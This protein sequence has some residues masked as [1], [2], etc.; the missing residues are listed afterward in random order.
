MYSRYE[1]EGFDGISNLSH[2]LSQSVPNEEATKPAVPTM[3]KEEITARITELE[4]EI[5][6]ETNDP[7][8]DIHLRT[9]LFTMKA[10]LAGLSK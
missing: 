1:R 2:L 3:T 7:I 4:K 9:E 8:R 10:Q 5:L 6:Q